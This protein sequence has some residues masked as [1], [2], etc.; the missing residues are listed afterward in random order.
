MKSTTRLFNNT[1]LI[2]PAVRPALGI[3][4]EFFPPSPPSSPPSLS[5]KTPSLLIHIFSNGGSASISNLYEQYAATS[6]NAEDT[7][8]PYHVTIFD[9]SPSVFRIQQTVAYLTIGMSSPA[10]RTVAIPALYTIATGL[11]AMINLGLW[12]TCFSIGARATTILP[13]YARDGGCISTVTQI[14]S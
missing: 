6:E 5:I 8:L 3:I 4:R 9:S 12:K 13:R 10:H 11:S 1:A 7:L 14:R 2:G